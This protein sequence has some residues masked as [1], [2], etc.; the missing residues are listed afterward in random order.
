[1]RS[2]PGFPQTNTDIKRGVDNLHEAS[3]VSGDPLVVEVIEVKPDYTTWSVTRTRSQAYRRSLAMRPFLASD[4]K[5]AEDAISTGESDR[6]KTWRWKPNKQS[7]ERLWLESSKEKE[8]RQDS[9]LGVVLAKVLLALDELYTC[10]PW[11]YGIL[12]DRQLNR[13]SAFVRSGIEV[14]AVWKTVS[15]FTDTVRNTC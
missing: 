11:I 8:K 13:L 4:G 1:M 6:V 3:Q 7:A 9:S 14:S 2:S 5:L 15:K 10:K 12:D